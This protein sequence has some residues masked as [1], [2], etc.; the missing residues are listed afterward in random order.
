[1]YLFFSN[2][3]NK[4]I[5][6]FIADSKCNS[7]KQ[8]QNIVVD[9]GNSLPTQMVFG[10]TAEE[11]KT[12]CSDM[13]GC[14]SF[15]Y[16][17]DTKKCFFKDKKISETSAEQAQTFCFTIYQDCEDGIHAKLIIFILIFN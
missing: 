1:M 2:N 16:C 3:L 13:D 12:K 9:E 5:F 11:C 8:K 4:V 14:L 6:I 10:H 15:R 17:P 7:Y